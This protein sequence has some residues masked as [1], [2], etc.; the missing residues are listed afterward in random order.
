MLSKCLEMAKRS[1]QAQKT[2]KLPKLG[3]NQ[4]KFAGNWSKL[5]KIGE[6]WLKFV[7]NES[8]LVQNE[9]KFAKFAQNWSKLINRRRPQALLGGLR[10]PESLWLLVPHVRYF[11]WHLY[12]IYTVYLYTVYLLYTVYGRSW[13]QMGFERLLSNLRH[14][15][16][17]LK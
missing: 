12:I 10:P 5:T 3:S 4:L 7:Q 8:K 2:P 13:L 15:V 9:S 11:I 17:R 1:Q 14:A 6:I 16:P